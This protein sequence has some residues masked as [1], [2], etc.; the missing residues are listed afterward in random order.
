MTDLSKGNFFAPRPRSQK[1]RSRILYTTE[2]YCGRH[3]R[4]FFTLCMY[5]NKHNVTRSSPGQPKWRACSPQSCRLCPRVGSAMAMAEAEMRRVQ[6]AKDSDVSGESVRGEDKVARASAWM[7]RRCPADRSKEIHMRRCPAKWCIIVRLVSIDA[8]IVASGEAEGL[9]C[10][11]RRR[12]YLSP[13]VAISPAVRARHTIR[14]SS[15]PSLV[16][17]APSRLDLSPGRWTRF[18]EDVLHLRRV[19]PSSE[20]ADCVS[21][22]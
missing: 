12:R 5:C 10:R 8:S 13:P 18:E 16:T 21:R 22:E 6:V 7:T 11:R 14:T 9:R 4:P 17:N 19:P 15:Y 3:R 20:P 2:H 1:A